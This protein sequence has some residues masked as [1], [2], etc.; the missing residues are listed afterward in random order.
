RRT[1][2]FRVRPDPKTLPVPPAPAAWSYASGERPGDVGELARTVQL[3]A[4][5]GPGGPVREL[6]LDLGD[7]EPLTQQVDGERGLH[8]PASCQRARRLERR[9]GQ[10]ALPVQRLDRLPAH[11]PADTGPG[12]PDDQAVPAELDGRGE[13]GDGH[14]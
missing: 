9:P 11:S 12:Q 8:P 1:W 7:P 13:D 6:D 2:G 14:V 4:Q 3:G 5:A 10:A